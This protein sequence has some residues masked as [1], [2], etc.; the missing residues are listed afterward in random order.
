[1]SP[2]QKNRAL[3]DFDFFDIIEPMQKFALAQQDGSNADG[4]AI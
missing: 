3:P 2:R 4:A 1:L